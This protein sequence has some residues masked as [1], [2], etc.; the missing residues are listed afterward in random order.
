M[1]TIG[2]GLEISFVKQ[3]CLH[4]PSF[5]HGSDLPAD[6]HLLII[7]LSKD[8]ISLYKWNMSSTELF[9]WQGQKMHKTPHI[10]KLQPHGRYRNIKRQVLPPASYHLEKLPKKQHRDLP[11][12]PVAETPCSQRRGPGF[13]RRSRN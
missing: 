6:C 10:Y 3:M 11:A 4:K 13:D 9:I 7:P 12:G 5:V 1:S 8:N 2:K